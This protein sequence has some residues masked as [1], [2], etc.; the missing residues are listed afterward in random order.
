[1]PR[2]QGAHA[3]AAN[4][5][6]TLPR[7]DRGVLDAVGR[8]RALT[9]VEELLS[10]PTAPYAE[11]FV[12]ARL[13]ERFRDRPRFRLEWT[14][15]ANLL[16]IY[17][18]ARAKHGALPAL[19]FSAH[20]DHPGFLFEPPEATRGA[21]RSRWARFLGG[22]PPA[23]CEGASARF[24]D[25]ADAA[26]LAHA[27]VESAEPE[28]DGGLRTR[29]VDVHGTLDRPAFGMWDLPVCQLRGTRL[30]ARACDDLLGAAAIVAVLEALDACASERALLCIFTRAEETGFVGCQALLRQGQGLRATRV[31]GLECSP[32]RATAKVG[33]G[34]VLRVGDAAT[35][36][37]PQLTHALQECA[38]ECRGR[39]GGFRFQRALMDGGRCESTA[40]NLWGV[41]A[42]GVCLALG[43][44][45][46]VGRDGR[47][48]PEFVDWN[49]FEDLVALLGA[50]VERADAG[51]A[52]E[53]QRARLDPVWRQEGLRLQASTERILARTSN[54]LRPA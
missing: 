11:D 32:R 23:A 38:R 43:N 19:A 20:L 48:A 50:C 1:M 29:L 37:D 28:P 33:S 17:Q 51:P 4:A 25:L 14:A 18:G 7:N 45:H 52:E 5:R 13:V 22:V 15:G 53:Q 30:S 35:V 34:V 16:V 54:A 40:Y 26:P 42:A 21:D 12:L 2:A 10:T 3:G 49:D 39:Q 9:I 36:F 24:F 27:R 8:A 44:Y 47:I 41:R 31:V 6:L 46:N